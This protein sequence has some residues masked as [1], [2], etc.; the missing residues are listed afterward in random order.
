[1]R[2]LLLQDTAMKIFDLLGFFSLGRFSVVKRD[3]L[4]LTLII[5]FTYAFIISIDLAE[6]VT[7]KF[8]KYE[9]LQLDE[10]P[11]LL[12]LMAFGLTWFTYRRVRE[13][14]QEIVLRMQAEDKIMRLLTENKALTQHLIK[15]QEAERQQLAIDLHDDIG[16]Y[17]LAIRLDAS[18][19]NLSMNNAP[20]STTVNL[21]ARRILSNAQH[22][23]EM[24]RTL[25]R[26]LRPA[27]TDTKGLFDSIQQLTLEW[28]QQHPHIELDSNIDRLSVVFTQQMSITI[29]RLIQETLTNISK[30]ANATSVWITLTL[31]RSEAK[32]YIHLEIK[33][34]GNGYASDT[35]QGMGM[36]GMRERVTSLM[37]EF[38]ITSHVNHGVTVVAKIPLMSL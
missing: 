33:D 20:V 25:M 11:F 37:G 9:N 29:Y 17:L 2:F 30:Y 27:P 38:H 7:A 14:D 22:I 1:M 12:L 34:N 18:A 13:R 16:Q 4:W 3:A 26:R 35:A 21:H 5:L 32:R 6:T 8:A 31:Q 24:T 23:Q 10:L 36:I 19:L 15:V 28:H